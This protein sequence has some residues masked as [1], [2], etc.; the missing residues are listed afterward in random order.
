M[1]NPKN[2]C[3]GVATAIGSV[4]LS[5]LVVW[6]SKK[7]IDSIDRAVLIALMLLP[8]LVYLIARGKLAEFKAAG[9]CFRRRGH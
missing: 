1:A 5:F 3:V 6:L 4:A 8:L 9:I 7:I 2:E